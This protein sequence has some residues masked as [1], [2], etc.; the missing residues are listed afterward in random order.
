MVMIHFLHMS[1]QKDIRGKL[2]EAMKAKDTLTMEVL[3]GLL[4]A[5]T[6]ESIQKGRGPN[7]EL[8][9]EEVAGLIRRLMKQRKEAAEHYF[10]GGR[11]DLKEKEEQEAVILQKFVPE[12]MGSDAV[13]ACVMKKKLE[14]KIENKMQKGLL[15]GAV[16]RD[17]KGKADGAEVK[18][19]V[20]EILGM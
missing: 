7:G 10:K 15:M 17:L 20:D 6:N 16:M 19:A 8:V 9:D 2:T 1:L 4:T 3:R 11:T 13:R 5:C 12:F 18:K 14:L